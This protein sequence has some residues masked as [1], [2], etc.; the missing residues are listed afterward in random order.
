VLPQVRRLAEA[1][2]EQTIFTRFIPAMRPGEG[3]GASRPYYERWAS[4]T[5]ERM[6][7][8]MVELVPELAALV[9]PAEVA[10]KSVYSP[11]TDPDLLSRLRARG[12][13]GGLRALAAVFPGD[14]PDVA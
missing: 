10:D 12:R 5:I 2:G 13:G 11:W 4:M 9:P 1:H 8:E 7:A 14:E 3:V 6:R